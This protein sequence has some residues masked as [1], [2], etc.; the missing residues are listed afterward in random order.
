MD[1]KE[2]YTLK[3]VEEIMKVSRRT[4][5]NWIKENKLEV[6]KPGGQYRVSQEALDKFL[7]GRR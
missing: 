2:I 6:T 1:R 7:S 5:Y 4:I 3:E